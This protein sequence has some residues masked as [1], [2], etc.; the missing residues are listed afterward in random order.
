MEIDK[1]T[2]KSTEIDKNTGRIILPKSQEELDRLCGRT[3]QPGVQARSRVKAYLPNSQ[4]PRPVFPQPGIEQHQHIPA[5]QPQP[6]FWQNPFYG[7][8]GFCT[9]IAAIPLG[10]FCLNLV[11]ENKALTT[12]LDKL[13]NKT[14]L[15]EAQKSFPHPSL[16]ALSQEMKQIRDDVAHL[17]TAGFEVYYEDDA[18]QASEQPASEQDSPAIEEEAPEL[19]GEPADTLEV[20]PESA[21]PV[22]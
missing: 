12:Q 10:F 9:L 14:A 2:L 11:Q 6:A 13:E 18:P 7:I 19:E 16:T 5:P 15:M 1:L 22:S 17:S 21:D 20:I 8:L 3:S 4:A